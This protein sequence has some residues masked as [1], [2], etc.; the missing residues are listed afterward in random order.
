M[1]H[2]LG[3]ILLALSLMLGYMA[4]RR[5]HR[6]RY[7]WQIIRAH[8]G[9]GIFTPRPMT[10]EMAVEWAMSLGS[11]MYVDTIHHIIFYK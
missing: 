10:Q 2:V 5:T 8:G 1:A 11:V 4:Y 7:I 9:G 6:T 3:T